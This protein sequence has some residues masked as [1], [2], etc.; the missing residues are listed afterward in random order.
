MAFDRAQRANSNFLLTDCTLITAQ[1][2][3]ARGLAEDSLMNSRFSS[4]IVVVCL[5][6]SCVPALFAQ[7]A[8]NSIEVVYTLSGSTVQTYNVDRQTGY[9]TQQGQGVTLDFTSGPATI[10]PSANDHF[11]YVTAFKNS[12]YLWVYSTDSTGVPQLPAIQTFSLT[13]SFSPLAIDPNGTVAYATRIFQNSRQQIAASIYSFSINPTTGMLKM[14]AKVATYPP[15]G[16]CSVG[17]D[18]ASFSV[19]GFNASGSQVY[20]SW[21]CPYY[22]TSQG[23]YYSRPV[24]QKTGALG[25]E[26]Q[27]AYWSNGSNTSTNLVN[28][29]PSAVLFRRSERLLVRIQRVGCCFAEREGAL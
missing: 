17:V 9:P 27:I 19:V 1:T 6:L 29:T 28:I 2:A 25:R 8:A 22:D 10:V 11:L 7:T 26:T 12:Q 5:V 15:N 23:F 3:G 16:P 14:G 24:N 21:Y 20:D 13:S 18:V 4:F